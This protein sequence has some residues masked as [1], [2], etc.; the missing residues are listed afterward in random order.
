[1][2]AC[3]PQRP[4]VCPLWVQGEAFLVKAVQVGI[5]AVCLCP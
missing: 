2:G 1:M 5:L 3:L 4:L